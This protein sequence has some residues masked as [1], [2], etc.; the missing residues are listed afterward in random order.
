MSDTLFFIEIDILRHPFNR[1]EYQ[2]V[3]DL[4][5]RAF[6]KR[7]RIPFSFLE[8]RADR[9][10]ADFFGIYENDILLGIMYCVYDGDLIYIFWFAINDAVRG[11]GCGSRILREFAEQNKDKRILL[12]IE[13]TEEPCDNPEQRKS[14]KNFYLRN[15]FQ[16]CGYRVREKGGSFEMLSLGGKVEKEE[17][18]HLLLQY[19]GRFWFAFYYG[20]HREKRER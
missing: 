17:Y 20:L 5:H 11:Q 16:E 7:E 12:N 15:G 8:K 6:P 2:R 4:Y 10:Q 1:E 19:F 3:M 18:E 14:R 13:D 9:K